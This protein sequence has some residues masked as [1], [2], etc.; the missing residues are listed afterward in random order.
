M[1]SK[2]PRA[3]SRGESFQVNSTS[4]DLK[5]CNFI[6][7]ET[8]CELLPNERCWHVESLQKVVLVSEESFQDVLEPTKTWVMVHIL[9]D[10]A[11]IGSHERK[12]LLSCIVD[13]MQASGIWN[14]NVDQSRLK[15][16][17]FGSH[18]RAQRKPKVICV[19]AVVGVNR[20][21]QGY[22]V[23]D[24]NDASVRVLAIHVGVIAISRLGGQNTHM[25]SCFQEDLLY[26]TYC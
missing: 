17:Y 15:F 23:I 26:F 1:L 8:L 19:V 5:V 22:R 9:W 10:V 18:K 25:M 6:H 14:R 3:M 16:F 20:V 13:Q 7:V 21:S 2:L 4:P 12:F 11:V 24:E